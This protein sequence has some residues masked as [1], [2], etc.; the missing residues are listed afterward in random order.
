MK[1]MFLVQ[2]M[3]SNIIHQ[4]IL[5]ENQKKQTLA[6]KLAQK[7]VISQCN[8]IGNSNSTERCSKDKNPHYDENSSIFSKEIGNFLLLFI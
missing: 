5:I 4:L 3:N 1:R 8:S 2:S 6:L 7:S